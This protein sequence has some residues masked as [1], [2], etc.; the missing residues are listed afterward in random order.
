MINTD[1]TQLLVGSMPRLINQIVNMEIQTPDDTE[2]VKPK[3]QIKILVSLFNGR[4]NIDNQVNKLIST[5]SANMY[6]AYKHH[7][8]MTQAAR[9]SY[10]S[11]H[12]ISRVNN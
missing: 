7:N 1:K 6:I 4:G 10:I 2:N 3:K 9:K 11:S 5:T 12:V 8:I